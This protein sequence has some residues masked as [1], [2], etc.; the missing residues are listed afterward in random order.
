M[1]SFLDERFYPR[2]A[3]IGFFAVSHAPYNAQ[4]P[5]LYDSFRTYHEIFRKKLLSFGVEVVDL[6]IIDREEDA[7]AAARRLAGESPDLIVCNM[8]TYATSSVFAPFLTE[9]SAPVILAALQPRAALDYTKANTRMQLENDNICAVPEFTGVAR[10]LGRRV[11]D[12][13]IGTLEGDAAADAALSEWCDIAKVLNALRGAR[14]GLLGHTMEAMYDMHADPT[15]LTRAFGIHVPLLE[16]D[17]IL[18][19]KKEVTKEE[20]A[21][22]LS[23]IDEVFDT[24]DP[25][26]DPIA[27]KL[28]DRDKTVAAV[29]AAALERL[30]EEKHLRGLAYYYEGTEGEENREA[31]SS[32]I[33][34]NSFLNARGVPMCG[35]YD[36]K[37]C[38]AML[39]MDTLGIGGS[40]A[41][42]PLRFRGEFYS[43]RARRTAP[44]C[45]CR[46]TPRSAQSEKIPRK[47]RLRRVGGI[48]T[49]RGRH[50]PLRH[51][52]GRGGRL[53]LYR[54]RRHL[55]ARSDPADGKYQHAR[56]VPPHDQRIRAAVGHGRSDPSLRP[57]HRAPRR[58]D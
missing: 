4:F 25:G 20:I 6:G 12:C 55:R 54:R 40:F 10:R 11:E 32:L 43:R 56:K 1:S 15:A 45:D 42:L 29:Y 22:S 34:G 50:H 21:L 17:D 18:R 49:P 37:T 7:F 27:E 2:Q 26:S 19:C 38:I 33:V 28:T 14:I 46:R 8:I 57:R 47:T 5:G 51:R 9:L 31:A 36:I 52:A 53:P 30:I 23:R 58:D 35:E 24:P 16:I 48:Q 44:H 41:E 3:K 39:I 13:I